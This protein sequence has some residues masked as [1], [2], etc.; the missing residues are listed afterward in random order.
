MVLSA[1]HPC[2]PGSIKLH[3]ENTWLSLQTTD[4]TLLFFCWKRILFCFVAYSLCRTSFVWCG[5]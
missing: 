5:M 1:P 3:I 4:K 2:F